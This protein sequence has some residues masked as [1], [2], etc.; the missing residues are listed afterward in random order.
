MMNDVFTVNLFEQELIYIELRIL[1]FID[2]EEKVKK[3]SEILNFLN[4]NK[5]LP[6]LSIL[7]Y[8]DIRSENVPEKQNIL[9]LSIDIRDGKFRFKFFNGINSSW[10]FHVQDLISAIKD[11]TNHYQYLFEKYEPITR[12][13]FKMQNKFNDDILSVSYKYFNEGDYEIQYLL[14]FDEN[15]KGRENVIL[16][17]LN[18]EIMMLNGDYSNLPFD[19]NIEFQKK[20]TCIPCEEARKKR[21]E[22]KQNGK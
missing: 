5:F 10:Y 9:S 18:K 1:T 16:S 13:F 4:N 21:E 20:S 14:I 22:E 19:I 11:K 2:C 15:M 6:H 7:Y 17:L 12:V 8:S 3:I